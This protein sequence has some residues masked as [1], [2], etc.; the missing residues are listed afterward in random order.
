MD[1]E[2]VA[3]L[4]EKLIKTYANKGITFDDESLYKQP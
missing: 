4:E 1:E 2:K 3:I